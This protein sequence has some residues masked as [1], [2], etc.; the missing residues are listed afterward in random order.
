VFSLNAPVPPAVERLAADL[1][2]DLSGLERRDDHS[3]L[4]KRLGDDHAAAEKRAR[5]VLRGAPAVEARI[6]EIGVF[7][8]PTAG[9]APVVYLAV[10]SPG[11]HDLHDRLCEAVPPVPNLEGEGYVPHV[12]LARGDDGSLGSPDPRDVAARLDGRSVGPVTWRVEELV[13]SDA[14]RGERAGRVPLPA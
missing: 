9:S 5:R 12:T 8:E 6:S 14:R 10:D 4:L 3:L 7:W 1:V 11:L 13:F 2:P